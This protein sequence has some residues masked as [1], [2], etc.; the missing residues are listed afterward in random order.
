MKRLAYMCVYLVAVM[1]GGFLEATLSAPP[2]SPYPSQSPPPSYSCSHFKERDPWPKSEDYKEHSWPKSEYNH[3]EYGYEASL[4]YKSAVSSTDLLWGAV[5]FFGAITGMYTL[6]K[7]CGFWGV[8]S[9]EQL[10]QQARTALHHIDSFAP[11]MNIL[12]KKQV[13]NDVGMVDESLLYELALAKRGGASI[14]AYMGNVRSHI[15]ALSSSQ[16]DLEKRAYELKND[17]KI[18]YL[19]DRIYGLIRQIR[20]SLQKMSFF[21]QYLEAHRSY[22]RLF[23]IEDRFGKRY[24]RE[25]DLIT[26]MPYYDYALIKAL[27]ACVLSKYAGAFALIEY[28]HTLKQDVIELE[29]T[30]SGPAFNYENRL[31]NAQML[32]TQL[33]GIR[34][35][36]ISDDEYVRLLPAY[37]H[38]QREKER[39]RLERERLRAEK[40]RI[41]VERILARNER[42]RIQQHERLLRVHRYK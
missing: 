34:D 19:H 10:I 29:R 39:L 32:V 40:E 25:L 21:I 3:E 22:F 13:T 27:R 35:L 4:H 28:V 14:D 23:E 36:I 11:L 12:E 17:H 20:E 37:E 26:Q 24:K 18:K 9:N 7:W 1:Q 6:G 42:M 2:P 8:V 5:G 33:A 38:A 16:K 41:E 15:N 31:S 30:V